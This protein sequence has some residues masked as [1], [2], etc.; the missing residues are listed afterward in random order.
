MNNTKLSIVTKMPST[1]AQ[2]ATRT[3]LDTIVLNPDTAKA[4]LSPPFQRPLKINAKVSE[5]ANEIKVSEVIP[6]ILT[7]G[8]LNGETYLL[9][10]QH[11]REAFFLSE[12][13]E[14]FV[15]IRKHI[16]ESL[17][18]M[19]DEFV[20]LNSSL[21]R[22]KPDDI[23]RGLE[24]SLDCLA[25]IRKKC[26]YVGYDM[27]RRGPKSPVVSM[28]AL[29]RCWFGSASDVPAT[30]GLS[31]A[32]LT[33]ELSM[34]DTIILTDFLHHA[35]KAWGVDQE[36]YKMWGALNLT[37]IMWLFR[38]TVITQY[39]TRTPKLTKE[40]FM[41]C[42]MALTADATYNDWLSGRQLREKDRSPAYNKIK[43]I[44]VKRLE[45]ELGK[46]VSFPQPSWVSHTG[47]NK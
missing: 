17:G 25:F 12:V 29:L 5:L 16:F 41:K 32:K 3:V 35:H 14:A 18:E 4:W 27:I 42:M 40:Q 8:V 39:S 10:G 26:P 33:E 47:S 37:I 46:K 6:G 1:P 23:L 45:E 31:A 7:L 24:P 20:K 19:G 38:R 44:F 11:R 30:G 13:K 21:V 22:L 15:D 36:Y 2:K 9:D 34:D 43:S 28:S